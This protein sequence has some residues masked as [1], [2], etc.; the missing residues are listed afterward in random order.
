MEFIVSF[1]LCCFQFFLNN[2]EL[3]A[4]FPGCS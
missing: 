4:K 1:I 2:P 3:F